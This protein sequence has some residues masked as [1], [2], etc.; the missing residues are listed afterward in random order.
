M[1][2]PLEI[3]LRSRFHWRVN[4]NFELDILIMFFPW[5][6]STER[7][8]Q[9]S[10]TLNLNCHFDDLNRNNW[11]FLKLLKSKSVYVYTFYVDM[12]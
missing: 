12:S 10:L 5:Q 11:P 4:Y 1:P 8:K 6:L 7:T 2:A 3:G 9:S